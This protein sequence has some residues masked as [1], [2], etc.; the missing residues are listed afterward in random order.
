MIHDNKENEDGRG[1]TIDKG[2]QK[3][4]KRGR[5]KLLAIKEKDDRIK[6]RDE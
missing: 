4:E 3:K 5:Q 1:K 2:R 6:R